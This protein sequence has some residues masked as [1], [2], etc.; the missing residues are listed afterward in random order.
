MFYSIE[1]LHNYGNGCNIDRGIDK[2]K[3]FLGRGCKP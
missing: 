1:A 2:G 3:F